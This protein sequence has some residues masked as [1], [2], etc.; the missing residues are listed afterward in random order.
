MDRPEPEDGLVGGALS[1]V[2]VNRS[3]GIADYDASMARYTARS[4]SGSCFDHWPKIQSSPYSCA[5]SVTW[6]GPHV[7]FVLAPARTASSMAA[8]GMRRMNWVPNALASRI[9][10]RGATRPGVPKTMHRQSCGSDRPKLIPNTLHNIRVAAQIHVGVTGAFYGPDAWRELQVVSCVMHT[11]IARIVQAEMDWRLGRAVEDHGRQTCGPSL[12]DRRLLHKFDHLRGVFRFDGGGEL[13][14]QA[15]GGQPLVD[16]LAVVM[17]IGDHFVVMLRDW[18]TPRPRTA[19]LLP[20]WLRPVDE[21]LHLGI[22]SCH[23]LPHRTDRAARRRP[24]VVSIGCRDN[25]RDS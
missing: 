6:F 24:R 3:T 7:I 14:D 9:P 21:G 11:R 20:D 5:R 16:R 12:G 25:G 10:D 13:V 2:T 23:G 19:G 18:R 17:Q 8:R 1:G 15:L 22:A 4:H